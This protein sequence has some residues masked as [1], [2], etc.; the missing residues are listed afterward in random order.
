MHLLLSVF[1]PPL[2]R[3]K[4]AFV[5]IPCD[6]ISLRMR[7]KHPGPFAWTLAHEIALAELPPQ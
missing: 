5:V 4:V 2:G 6:L 7:K 1:L 3:V